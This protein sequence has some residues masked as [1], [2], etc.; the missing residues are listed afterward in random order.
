MRKKIELPKTL[1]ELEA[2]GKDD[3]KELWFRYF[4]SVP[5]IAKQSMIRMLW[6]KI[7]CENLNL[8]IEQKNITRLN[9]YSTDPEKYI[10][11]S[12]KAKYHLRNGM[13]IIKTYKG[14][15]YKVLVKSKKEFIYD[16]KPYK[17]L[18]AVALTICCKKVSGYDFFGLNNSRFRNGKIC[19][20]Q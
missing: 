4:K 7:Q 17:T 20:S 19:G 10:E 6:Y 9:R 13:E 3:I 15:Q 12:H 5:A 16:G 11:K 1:Q 14:R 18:S 2:I 8:H